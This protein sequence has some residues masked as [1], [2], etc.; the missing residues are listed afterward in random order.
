MQHEARTWTF[1]DDISTDLLYPQTAYALPLAEAAKLVFSANRPGWSDLVEPGDIIVGGRNFGMGSSRAAVAL[2]RRLGIG[3]C[4]AESFSTLYLRNCVNYALPALAAP[5]VLGLVE[6]GDRIHVDFSTGAIE[7]RSQGTR[8]MAPPL[9]P[10][11]LTIIEQGGVI[12]SLE[13]RGL[14]PAAPTGASAP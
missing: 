9:P 3:A 10:A 4:L 12:A 2:L 5:G 8:L 1:G 6:E 13:A 11:L 14:I 7:N